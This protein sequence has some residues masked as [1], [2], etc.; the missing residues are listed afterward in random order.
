MATDYTTLGSFNTGGASSLNGELIQKLY[1]AETKSVVKPL[2]TKLELIDTEDTLIT[3]VNTKVNELLELVKPFDLFSSSNNVFEQVSATTTGESAVFDAADV[4][5]LKK[6]TYNINI[7]GLATADVY[8]S[9]KFTIKTDLVANGQ[10]SGDSITINGVVFTTEGKTYEDLAS[11]ININGVANAS[12]E[13]VSDTEFRLVIKSTEPGS[14]NQLTI[15]Q[16]G[17]DLG[18]EDLVNNHPVTATNLT[19]I[20]DGVNYDIS[21]NSITIDDNLKITA[22]KIGESSLSIQQDDSAII[23][24]VEAFTNKYNEIVD[25]I[26]QEVYSD[27]PSTQ[28]KSALKSIASDIKNLMFQQ[29]GLNDE[30]IF[31]VGFSFDKNG[32][33]TVDTTELG[34]ALT[35]DVDKVKDL[36]LGAAEDKGFGTLLK[37]HLD[38]L[39]SYDG[40][41]T[42]YIDAMS[43]RKTNLEE[44]KEKTISALDTKYDAMASQ[45]SA[46]ATVI[47]KMESSFSALK[48]MIAAEN[49]SN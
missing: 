21:S 42:R 34:K 31:N 7:T 28:D 32:G 41:F 24:A 15:S 4:G 5:A 45:F 38:N 13:Q 17:V 39:N 43:T 44:E 23:P 20:I 37:E 25:M 14:A 47:S 29:F 9:N 40:L 18:L 22:T 6:G 35:D 16:T 33:L 36:F 49:S 8:Q 2:E 11:D 27:N 30:T 3:D 12:V 48:Q 26:N 46:Y 1:D 10:D 19:A